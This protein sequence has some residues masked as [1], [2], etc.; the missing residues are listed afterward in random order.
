MIYK[1][2]SIKEIIEGVY[3]DTAIHE[4]LDIWDV[5]EWG[6]E[7]LELIGA[8]L[9]YEELVAE[10]C[11]K[12]HR[13][14]LP[15]NLHLL[16]SVS[17]NGNPLKQC[18]GTFGAIS[19]DPGPPASNQNFIDGKLVDTENFP[20]KGSSQNRGGDCYYTNDN[21]I[22]TS[23]ASGCL[24][25]AFR[26]IKVDHEGFPMVPDHVSYKKAMKSYITMMIDRIGWRK[27]S[28]PENLY[29]DSQRDWEWYVKQ[30][31]G[32]A[33]MPNL[34]KVDNIRLQWMKLRPSQTAHGTFYTDLGNQER[35]MMG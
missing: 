22:I 12:E 30:A 25:L 20:L 26:G 35:R 8:G 27:G 32:A 23:F 29:R 4:E 16:D 11:V 3:R 28:V 34:D 21:F 33:N 7:A 17:Y 24:L 2:T 10:V 19:T 14:K 31:R 6:G 15:C 9:Q 1:F 18:T 5:I 13:A